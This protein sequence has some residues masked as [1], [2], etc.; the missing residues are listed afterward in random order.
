MNNKNVF[1]AFV[2]EYHH[3]NTQKNSR[4]IE[5]MWEWHISGIEPRNKTKVFL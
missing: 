3:E 5:H 1:L 2:R 4:K